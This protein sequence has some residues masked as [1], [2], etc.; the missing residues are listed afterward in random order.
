MANFDKLRWQQCQW[1]YLMLS[2]IPLLT[3]VQGNNVKDSWDWE[4]SLYA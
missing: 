4:F 3:V 1:S 2:N